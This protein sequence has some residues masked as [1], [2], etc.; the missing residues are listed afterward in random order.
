MS[1]DYIVSRMT[2][3]MAAFVAHTSIRLPDDVL[4]K[5]EELRAS[6][7]VPMACRIY[8][9]MFENMRLAEELGRPTCQD[10]GLLQFLIRC[11][12]GFPYMNDIEHILTEAVLKATAET[13]LRP[14]AVEAFDEVN[15]ANNTGLGA[16]TI[17][18][19]IVPDSDECEIYTYMA[20]GGCSLPGQSTVLM[21]G[22]GYPGAVKFVMDRM[23]SYGLNACP[24]L[25]VGVGIGTTSET[26]AM[27]AKHALMRPVGSHNENPRAAEL[28]EMLEEGINAIGFG[29]QGMGG[30]HSVM[31]VNVVGTAHHPATLGV[32]VTVGCWS[33]RRGCIVF[34]RDL[35]YRSVT[36]SKFEPGSIMDG[37]D[38]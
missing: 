4:S 12:S 14:N 34:D 23:T 2:D 18:W 30:K 29:P 31:G 9:L 25:L 7:N 28:E 13:P 6:E 24:P 32:A 1:P 10:T 35:N 26:A 3:T 38:R 37:G 15:T 33:H 17:W 8:D 19:E 5:L 22:E 21:P 11:G 20:G 36:H 27:N 16:P